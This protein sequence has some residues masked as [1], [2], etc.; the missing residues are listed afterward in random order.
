MSSSFDD[1]SVY[2]HRYSIDTGEKR[3]TPLAFPTPMGA[4]YQLFVVAHRGANGWAMRLL[5]AVL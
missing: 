1:G 3:L 4:R 5:S 2:T